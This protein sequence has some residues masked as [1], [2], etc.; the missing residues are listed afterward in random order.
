MSRFG[1]SIGLSL[2]TLVLTAHRLPAPIVEE[3]KPTPAPAPQQSE[4]PKR[5]HS[6]RSTTTEQ[7]SAQTETKTKAAS[8][9][10]SRGPARFAGTWT[11]KVNQGLLGHVATSLTVDANASSVELSRNLGGST[12]PATTNGSTLSW[13]SGVAGEI[14]WTLTPNSDGQTAQV[15]MKGVMLNETTTF[16]RGKVVPSTSR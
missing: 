16:R 6:A 2:I 15:T 5:K 10:V 9:P 1:K 12:R 14:N 4:A 11:G 13:K 8:A 7:S 3:E